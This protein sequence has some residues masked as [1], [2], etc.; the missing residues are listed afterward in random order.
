[1]PVLSQKTVS[2]SFIRRIS[3]PSNR[4]QTT[5]IEMSLLIIYRNCIRR[6]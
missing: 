5:D 4:I 3:I 2:A 6:D 1:M